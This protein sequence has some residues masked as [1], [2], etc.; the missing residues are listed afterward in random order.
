MWSCV[1]SGCVNIIIRYINMCDSFCQVGSHIFISMIMIISTER[2]FSA[3]NIYSFT[4][5]PFS[6][7]HE[8][9]YTHCLRITFNM[10]NSNTY[11]G[12]VL[13]HSIYNLHCVASVFKIPVDT[14]KSYDLDNAGPTSK[15]LGQHCTN[16]IQMFLC[17][18]GY[19]SIN[20][21]K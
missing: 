8:Q 9:L 20:M 17:L 2:P 21:T 10:K 13:T 18:L 16:V 12:I 6:N 5:L 7:K 15:T 4:E 19:V 3:S 14:N 11:F 1:D